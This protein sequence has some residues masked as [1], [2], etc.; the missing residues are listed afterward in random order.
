MNVFNFIV[1]NSWLHFIRNLLIVFLSFIPALLISKYFAES[2]AVIYMIM[3]FLVLIFILYNAL[4]KI[5]LNHIL[6]KFENQSLNFEMNNIF[7]KK[8]YSFH[9][10]KIESYSYEEN[11]LFIILRIH[12]NNKK[13][14]KLKF[15]KKNLSRDFELFLKALDEK[16]INKRD[17][18]YNK[19]SSLIFS[20]ILI[21]FLFVLPLLIYFYDWKI[22]IPILLILYANAIFFILKTLRK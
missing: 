3:T 4:K 1:V 2:D 18:I 5:H 13:T 15:L 11:L 7:L 12:C 6:V 10:N 21:V 17:C 9:Y 14:F 8:H 16:K 20:Y 19:N 22:N